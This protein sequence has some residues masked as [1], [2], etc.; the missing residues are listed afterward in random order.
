MTFSK[1]KTGRR[2]SRQKDI[3]FPA[4]SIQLGN[5]HRWYNLISGFV[6]GQNFRRKSKPKLFAIAFLDA[7]G[8][9]YDGW[10]YECDDFGN[11]HIHAIVILPRGKSDDFRK[12]FKSAKYRAFKR[13]ITDCDNIQVKPFKC[14][15]G[16][17]IRMAIVDL[18]SYTTKLIRPNHRT[19]QINDEF[20]IYPE[21]LR[22]SKDGYNL[23]P[24][25]QSMKWS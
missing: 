3:I 7:D 6:L 18:I 17:N 24:T 9:K 21:D 2:C 14:P 10:N 23:R 11:I 22:P 15:R 19:R 16:K 20:R 4:G 12:L 25:L 8:T 13:S 1:S 5:F